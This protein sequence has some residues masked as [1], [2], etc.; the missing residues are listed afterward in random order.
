M[1]ENGTFVLF[2][3]LK[4]LSLIAIAISVLAIA[5]G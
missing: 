3:V 5:F 2:E 1:N 4:V